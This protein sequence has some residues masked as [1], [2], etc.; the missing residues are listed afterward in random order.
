VDRSQYV[1]SSKGHACSTEA[2]QPPRIA[3]SWH[4][5]MYRGEQ[6]SVGLPLQLPCSA[7]RP[8]DLHAA[9]PLHVDPAFSSA[10]SSAFSITQ[11][12]CGGVE[13]GAVAVD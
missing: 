1:P 6:V 13:E 4:G 3:P 5:R 11:R 9:P 10:F 8:A 7:L 12:L 2:T